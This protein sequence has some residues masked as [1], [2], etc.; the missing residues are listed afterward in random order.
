M[1][2]E[3]ASKC[4]PSS[5]L[6][7]KSILLYISILIL[8]ILYALEIKLWGYS[9]PCFIYKLTGFKCPGCGITH[10]LISLISFDYRNAFLSN[11]YV[12]ITSPI[13][14]YF[15]FRN[16]LINCRISKNKF[17]RKENLILY[18]Y[19]G[20]LIIWGFVRNIINY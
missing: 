1:H 8:L 5:I 17:T 12:F 11:P 9:I 10:S 6:N 7:T 18:L 16:I 2:K 3:R 20:G 14:L 13:I 4:W 19:L 15:L